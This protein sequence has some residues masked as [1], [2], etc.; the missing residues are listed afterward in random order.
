VFLIV[1]LGNP[2]SRY[3]NTRHNCGF[4]VLENLAK[5]RNSQF[6]KG[7]GP[8]EILEVKIESYSVLLAK[9]TTY[10]NKSGIAVDDLVKRYSIQL[11]KLLILCDDRS[12]P[13][14]K[15]RLRRKG[16]H[17]GHRGLGSIINYI[18][19]NEF[20]R[21][22]LGINTN[23]DIDAVDYVLSPFLSTERPRVN[24][25]IE[26]A[27]QAVVDFVVKGIEWTMNYYNR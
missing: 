20:P 24:L 2:G 7:K 17:G 26:T 19:T 3:R 27:G 22:R 1:G 21:L 4:M 18:R 5:E 14:G 11:F 9:P 25:M 15:L 13:V 12:L 10:M 16:S 6:K 8:Y 23:P